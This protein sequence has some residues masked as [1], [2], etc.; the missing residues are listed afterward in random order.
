MAEPLVFLGDR[1][2]PQ[3]QASLSLHDAGFVMGATVTDLVRTFRHVLY[4]WPEHLARFR[5][6]CR[7]TSITPPLTDELITAR[8]EELV[9]HNA[10]LLLPEQDLAL[11]LFATPGPIGYYLGE[12]GGVGTSPATFGM[13]T[14]PLPFARYRRWLEQGAAL[15]VSSVRQV[16]F[17]C[18][19]PHIKMRSRLHWWLADREAQRIDPGATALLLDEAG[20]LTETAAANV[21][22]VRGGTVLSPP[23]ARILEGVSLRVVIEL[24]GRLGIPFEERQMSI[25]DL[26]AAEEVLLTSTPYCLMGVSRLNGAPVPWPGKI[27]QRLGAAWNEEVGM[28]IHEQILRGS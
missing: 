14:F 24:C 7:S 25:A 17:A 15:V 27:L 4:R 28:D 10:S 23:R 26:A 21:L 5:N 12:P 2:L 22:V 6:S 8:A 19:D 20:G 3:S 18:V 11:V 9:R 1:L 16:P 13:H